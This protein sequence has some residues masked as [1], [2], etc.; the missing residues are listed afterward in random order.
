MRIIFATAAVALW[1]TN[2][3]AAKFALAELTVAQL[4]TLQFGSATVCFAVLRAR[5]AGTRALL[6]EWPSGRV[7]LVGVVGLTGTIFLQYLAFALGDILEANVIAYAWPLFVAIWAALA[8]GNLQARL[9]LLLAI[10]GFA[11]VVL[12]FDARGGLSFDSSASLGYLL[13]VASAACMAFY[14]VAASRMCVSGER[15]LLP[16]T[17]LGTATALVISLVQEPA[18][19]SPVVWWMAVYIG[20]GPMAAGFALWTRAMKG[21]GAKRFAPIGYATPLL[22]TILLLLSGEAFTSQTL[23]GATMVLVCSIGVLVIDRVLGREAVIQS[24]RT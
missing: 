12:I 20:I 13:A 1:S 3:L 21:D 17:A 11:G 7:V 10:V 4:L 9:G 22:S 18:W 23:L 2:A 19:P 14:T 15:L 24:R 16:A 8:N 5:Q 6:T